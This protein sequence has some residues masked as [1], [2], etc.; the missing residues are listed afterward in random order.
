MVLLIGLAAK[1]AILIVEFARVKHEQG[2]DSREAAVTAG[3]LRFRAI[4][5]TAF[6]FILGVVPLLIAS[7]AG[8][9]ARQSLGTTVLSGML[10]ATI[11]GTL[12][13]PTFYVGIQDLVERLSGRKRGAVPAA[14]E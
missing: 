5:M 4:M 7:G 9:A 3:N 8:A 14:G 2:M 12:L 1:N 13:V 11:V 6:A 10:A